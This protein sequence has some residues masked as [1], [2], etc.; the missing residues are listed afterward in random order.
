MY[1]PTQQVS[2]TVDD[3]GDGWFGLDWI[4]LYW[5]LGFETWGNYYLPWGNSVRLAVGVTTVLGGWG[6]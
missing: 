5:P 6:K 4:W 2:N 3:D 1:I